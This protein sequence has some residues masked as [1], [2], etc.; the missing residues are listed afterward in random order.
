[1]RGHRPMQDSTM[2]STTNTTGCLSG[3]QSGSTRSN[4]RSGS[5]STGDQGI[6][7]TAESPSWTPAE[8]HTFMVSTVPGQFIDWKNGTDFDGTDIAHTLKTGA[9]APETRTAVSEETVLRYVKVVQ[10]A[11]TTAN[12]MT[13]THFGDNRYIRQL[14][15]IVR[16]FGC[17]RSGCPPAF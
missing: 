5:R 11:K 13:V 6:I 15:R 10:V 3:P 4:T 16:A 2:P 9:I 8:I 14:H 1:M 7:Y 12:S 17:H